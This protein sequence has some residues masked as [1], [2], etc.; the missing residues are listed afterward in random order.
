MSD[1]YTVTSAN[2]A[3]T[4]LKRDILRG[5][6]PPG[7][8]LLMSALKARYSTGVGPMREVLSQL[9]AERLV[10]SINQKGYRVANMSVTELTDVYDA[11]ARLEALIVRLALE[12]GDD[13]WEAGVVAMAH[14]LSRVDN[15]CSQQEMLD[16]WD[17]RHKA[18]HTAIAAGCGSS[19]LMQTRAFLA[20]Q[21][22][23]YRQIWL[24][25]TVFS[26]QALKAKRVEHQALL[27]A[28]LS[29]NIESIERD[30]YQHL[31]T[32]V[33]IIRAMLESDITPDDGE[34]SE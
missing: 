33:P 15:L 23:R 17:A 29:R 12:R 34:D 20:D 10:V 8:R 25:R 19:S 3:Y 5:E 31:M 9:V 16:I 11:R 13:V 24:Q 7:S 30:I 32:P 14:T 28:I 21:A 2:D 6:F 1:A 22:E 18:F 27:A 4:R 26:P